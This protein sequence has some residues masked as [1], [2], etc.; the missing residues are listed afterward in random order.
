M[1]MA[2]NVLDKAK[3]LFTEIRTHWKTPEEGKYVPYREYKDI[4]I[5]V[6]SNYAGS[7]L[8]EY[9]WFGAGCYLMMYHY[10]LPY[11]TFTII[12][13]INMPLKTAAVQRVFLLHR[14]GV[15]AH[16]RSGQPSVRPERGLRHL[17]ERAGGDQLRLRL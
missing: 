16:H 9:I 15:D 4:F 1:R 6:G 8:L 13:L 12:G 10:H 3:G 5:A 14:A 7:K 17:Y 2:G 11:L